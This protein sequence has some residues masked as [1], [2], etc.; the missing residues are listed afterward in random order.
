VYLGREFLVGWAVPHEIQES[1]DD[2][3]SDNCSDN[4]AMEEPPFRIN[5]R[6][7]VVFRKR[8]DEDEDLASEKPSETPAGVANGVN[9]NEV[10][11]T[12][13][14]DLHLVRRRPFGKKHGIAFTA[15]ATQLQEENADDLA[16]VL[17]PQGEDA[18][19]T[20]NDRFVKPTGRVGVAEDKHLYVL[21]SSRIS[22]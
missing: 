17:A 1:I 18:L 2:V 5:K 13:N 19:L 10:H 20:A 11:S 3:S 9:G 12:L 22:I 6:R 4:S 21:T 16:M 14:S 8:F 15:T 7:K